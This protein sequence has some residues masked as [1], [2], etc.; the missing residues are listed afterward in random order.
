MMHAYSERRMVPQ[1]A[2]NKNCDKTKTDGTR[3]RRRGVHCGRTVLLPGRLIPLHDHLSK[4]CD[5]TLGTNSQC[6]VWCEQGTGATTAGLVGQTSRLCQ[7]DMAIFTTGSR[8][9]S[10]SGRT[11]VRAIHEAGGHLRGASRPNWEPCVVTG[12]RP[13]ISW[14]RNSRETPR[15][16]PLSWSRDNAGA[17]IRSTPT[18]IHY[19]PAALSR[20]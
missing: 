5:T 1:N 18:Y 13:A 20:R 4:I 7:E 12:E 8:H 9:A 14:R 19:T 10:R 6:G 3:G 17:R 2:S 15:A 16:R 11:M